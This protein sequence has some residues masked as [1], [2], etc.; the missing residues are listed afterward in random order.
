[1]AHFK[2]V[3]QGYR[4]AVSTIGNKRTGIFIRTDGQNDGIMVKAMFDPKYNKNVYEVFNTRGK[5]DNTFSLVTRFIGAGVASKDGEE[6]V[7]KMQKR[8]SR[9][10]VFK[11]RRKRRSSLEVLK[12]KIAKLEAKNVKKQEAVIEKMPQQ[13]AEIQTTEAA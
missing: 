3:A 13:N 7:T 8:I 12:E 9:I 11:K 1:M 4:S 2:A 10:P 5:G 6:A